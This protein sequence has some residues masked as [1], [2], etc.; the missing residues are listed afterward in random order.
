MAIRLRGTVCGT[1][2]AGFRQFSQGQIRVDCRF[3]SNRKFEKA[4]EVYQE[5]GGVA[6]AKGSAA[7]RAPEDQWPTI[8]GTL[9]LAARLGPGHPSARRSSRVRAPMA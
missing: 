6:G 5:S 3:T 7:P 4:P 9:T 8:R 1:I 2:T